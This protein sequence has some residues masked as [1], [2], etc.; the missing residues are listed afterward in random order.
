MR[1]QST[2]RI[3]MSSRNM[4]TKVRRNG[5]KLVNEVSPDTD[6]N[7]KEKEPKMTVIDN[8]KKSMLNM[9]DLS[10]HPLMVIPSKKPPQAFTKLSYP[11]QSIPDSGCS[12]KLKDILNH[13]KSQK[14]KLEKTIFRIQNS[15]ATQLQ[16]LEDRLEDK[17]QVSDGIINLHKR[18]FKGKRNKNPM[19]AF[20]SDERQGLPLPTIKLERSSS[21]PES[22]QS[23]KKVFDFESKIGFSP[24]NP[25]GKYSINNMMAPNISTSKQHTHRES[26][27]SRQSGRE[28]VRESVR[29]DEPGRLDQRSIISN[30]NSIPAKENSKTKVILNF[31]KNQDS[32]DIEYN[33]HDFLVI[34]SEDTSLFEACVEIHQ[35]SLSPSSLVEIVYTHSSVIYGNRMYIFGGAPFASSPTSVY[36]IVKNDL[37]PIEFDS[38]KVIV[39]R[40]GL[41]CALKPN[42]GH[43]FSFG[44]EH[45]DI[46]DNTLTRFDLKSFTADICKPNTYF[47]MPVARRFCQMSILS[48]NIVI[49]GGIDQHRG[50]LGDVWTWSSSKYAWIENK[51]VD[52][53]KRIYLKRYGHRMVSIQGHTCVVKS[54]T[55]VLNSLLVF[56][57]IL[58]EDEFSHDLLLVKFSRTSRAVRFDKLP[59]IGLAPSARAFHTLEY[60]K[61]LHWVVVYGGHNIISD[62]EGNKNEILY[63]SIHVL[64]LSALCWMTL[65]QSGTIPEKFKHSSSMINNDIII[66]GGFQK[67]YAVSCD[68]WKMSF[69]KNFVDVNDGEETADPELRER[70]RII[71][72]MKI[73]QEKSLKRLK[74]HSL[75]SYFPIM[76]INES[77]RLIVEA[78]K[79]GKSLSK[80]Y[81]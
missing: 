60:L 2:I 40:S 53:T 42:T 48:D 81:F 34:Q 71:K 8:L 63:D 1:R 55:I 10:V 38:A 57:G 70:L 5:S 25:H 29:Q 45:M 14:L 77:T 22:H 27:I 59:T 73:E 18:I 16:G 12:S 76:D 52:D 46:F 11:A 50:L 68:M 72:R 7:I 4:D 54:N 56:G 37:K 6:E 41:A 30:G 61:N 24:S 43:I 79:R 62:E 21:K 20:F 51:V 47:E 3:N 58:E 39:K 67:D 35:V 80:L 49:Y 64:N 66:F 33:I 19:R 31:R 78:R 9:I 74:S 69:R 44:G 75:H 65:K 15:S 13:N 32:Q 36:D 17:E 23:Q 28:S 26:M